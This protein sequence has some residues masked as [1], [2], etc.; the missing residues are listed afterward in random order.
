MLI[1]QFIKFEL[2]GPGPPG[3][4]CTTTDYFR[5]KPKEEKSSSGL[6][7]FTAEIVQEALYF[8]SL[9]LGRFTYKI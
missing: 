4:T 7:I 2:R 3:R 8:T 5:D 9:Y 6:V 1:E